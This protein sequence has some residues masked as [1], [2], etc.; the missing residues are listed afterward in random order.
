M[1]SYGWSTYLRCKFSSIY[2]QDCGIRRLTWNKEKV[3]LQI[4]CNFIVFYKILRVIKP[5]SCESAFVAVTPNE[6][7]KRILIKVTFHWTTRKILF[8]MSLKC[9]LKK[10][11]FQRNGPLD[12]Q[13]ES[14]HTGFSALDVLSRGKLKIDWKTDDRSTTQTYII[15]YL[16]CPSPPR[17]RMY[18]FT[19]SLNSIHYSSVF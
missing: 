19:E 5:P 2:C 16:S 18:K 11:Q 1:T 13:M 7:L 4:W 8:E 9:Y 12:V 6:H 14:Q 17:Y 15:A 3:S 10:I